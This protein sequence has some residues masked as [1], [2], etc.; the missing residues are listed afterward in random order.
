ML[1]QV[2]PDIMTWCV[3]IAEVTAADRHVHQKQGLVAL[4]QHQV[5]RGLKPWGIFSRIR[6]ERCIGIDTFPQ[7][8]AF[9]ANLPNYHA[10]IECFR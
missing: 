5:R 10:D 2:R 4:W 6:I 7:E 1:L 9:S 3:C 8:Q